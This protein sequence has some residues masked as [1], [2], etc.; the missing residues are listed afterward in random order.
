MAEETTNG[1]GRWLESLTGSVVR[2]RPGGALGPRRIA[3]H[4]FV[5]IL[6]GEVTYEVEGRPHTISPGTI[7]LGKPF[8]R[9]RY[10]WDPRRETRHAF[11]HFTMR[12]VPADLAE[13]APWPE[14]RVM[15]AGDPLRP[16]FRAVLEQGGR[17]PEAE[18]PPSPALERLV[19]AMLSLFVHGTGPSE[20]RSEET[21]P[22][23]VQRALQWAADRL[24]EEPAAEIRLDDLA[25]AGHVSAKHLA[26]LFSGSVG[27]SPMRAVRHLRLEHA[28]RLL[29]RSNATV[30]EVARACGFASP[31]HF[32]RVFRAAYG[33]APSVVQR[34]LR[35][36]ESPPASPLAGRM[37]GIELGEAVEGPRS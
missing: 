30:T 34:R 29:Q 27:V 23:P 21:A 35:A 14:W 4:E 8:R 20:A 15:P 12:Y 28:V 6:A 33:A 31:F 22:E 18:R 7:L 10:V 25:E 17:G 5:W 1:G 37:R 26:R 13:R 16:L 24:A 9:E 32:A 2:F 11:F 19:A 3:N 36:G